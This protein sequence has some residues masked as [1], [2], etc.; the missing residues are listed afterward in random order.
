M[1]KNFIEKVCVCVGG[2]GGG[3]AI[4]LCNGLAPVRKPL[5]KSGFMNIIP[6]T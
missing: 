3:G 1:K 6:D 2:G 5:I 4:I